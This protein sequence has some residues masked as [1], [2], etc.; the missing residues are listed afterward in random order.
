MVSKRLQLICA[1]AEKMGFFL[2]GNVVVVV[3]RPLKKL[4]TAAPFHTKIV[5]SQIMM[6]VV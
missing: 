3:L 4:A 6:M 1:K 2:V 5:V